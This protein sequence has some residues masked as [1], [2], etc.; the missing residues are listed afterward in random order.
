MKMPLVGA[1]VTAG[2]AA[3]YAGSAAAQTTHASHPSTTV[4]AARLHPLNTSVT[5][6]ESTGEATFTLRGDTLVISIE[7]LHVP[8]G[9][10]H[11]QHFH[12]FKDD[13]AAMCPTEAADVNHDGLIDL[14]ETEP[15]AGTTMVPFDDDPVALDI[16][17]G[18]YPTASAAGTYHY[19]KNVSMKA[20]TAAFANKFGDRQLDLDRRVVF[21]HG[22]LPASKLPASVASLGPVPAQVTLPIACGRIERVAQ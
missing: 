18:T 2:I 3:L 4:Y 13:R 5:G 8:P 15:M 17:H 12:G 16:A 22:V 20:L 6:L 19:R 14:I 7:A 11:W 9:I 10:T 21:I 1:F